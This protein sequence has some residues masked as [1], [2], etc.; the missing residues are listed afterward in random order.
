MRDRRQPP[1][2]AYRLTPDQLS[3]Q[4]DLHLAHVHADL[5]YSFLHKAS[6]D[7]EIRAKTEQAESGWQPR[8]QRYRVS[9]L[10][11]ESYGRSTLASTRSKSK[12]L[13]FFLS[14]I[15]PSSPELIATHWSSARR[16]L[17]PGRVHWAGSGGRFGFGHL[18]ASQ[19]A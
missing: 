9:E 7:A 5:S 15:R 13:V 14:S 18:A 12:N 16:R 11:F 1:L 6:V 17:R 3:A 19:L 4:F 8:A 2:L 10:R